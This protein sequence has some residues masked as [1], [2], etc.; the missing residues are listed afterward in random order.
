MVIAQSTIQLEND[1]VRVTTWVFANSGDGTGDHTHEFDYL[2][3]PISGGEFL[4]KAHG[5]ADASMIQVAGFTYLGTAGTRHDV[6]S[7]SDHS[8]V[9]VEIELKGKP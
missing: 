9:F 3:V 5:V 2:V 1:R 8:V 6:M 4:V 7:N